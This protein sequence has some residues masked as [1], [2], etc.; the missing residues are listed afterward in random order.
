M[1]LYAMTT[2]KGE[3]WPKTLTIASMVD[4]IRQQNNKW[5]QGMSV[6][7]AHNSLNYQNREEKDLGKQVAQAANN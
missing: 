5:A 1:T 4:A 7:K 6:I 2:Q 3:V